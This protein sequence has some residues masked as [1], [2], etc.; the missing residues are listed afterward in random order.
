MDQY[1]LWSDYE[2]RHDCYQND[3]LYVG[4][5]SEIQ[6]HYIH[7]DINLA[8]L[9]QEGELENGDVM[10]FLEPAIQP[11]KYICLASAPGAGG[12]FSYWDNLDL[13]PY[14][15]VID[16]YQEEYIG[17][18]CIFDTEQKLVVKRFSGKLNIREIN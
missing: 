8:T 4:P 6:P 14:P 3:I 10:Y 18:C 17:M 13:I 2:S 16:D 11:S 5:I 15:S 1:I 12:N 9:I 7:S